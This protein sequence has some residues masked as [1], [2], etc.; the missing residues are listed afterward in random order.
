M[1]CSGMPSSDV[2]PQLGVER[3]RHIRSSQSCAGQQQCPSSGLKSVGRWGE[4]ENKCET[5]SGPA[6]RYQLPVA[7]EG[8]GKI[9]TVIA[10]AC[11]CTHLDALGKIHDQAKALH[12]SLTGWS[13]DYPSAIRARVH[14]QN[15]LVEKACG[16]D[17]NFKSRGRCLPN[18]PSRLANPTR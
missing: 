4:R 5:R 7:A 8:S 18:H 3:R 10:Y 6:G 1:H 16:N 9:L 14:A 13:A 15:G 11:S 17:K 2:T 12:C